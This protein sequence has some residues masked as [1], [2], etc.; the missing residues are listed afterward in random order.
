ME[1]SAALMQSGGLLFLQAKI[2][3]VEASAH[4]V[5]CSTMYGV[6]CHLLVY[7]WEYVLFG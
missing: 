6:V 5:S 1:A 7:S 4:K 3:K 2:A